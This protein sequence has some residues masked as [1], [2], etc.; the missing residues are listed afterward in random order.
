MHVLNVQKDKF[1]YWKEKNCLL[2]KEKNKGA[3]ENGKCK[4]SKE[5]G[6]EWMWYRGIGWSGG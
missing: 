4:E 5:A 2:N 3:V 1:F 6:G